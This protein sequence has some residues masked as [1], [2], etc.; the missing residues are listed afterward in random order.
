MGALRHIVLSDL[1]LGALNSVLTNVG[2][3]GVDVDTATAAPVLTSLGACLRTLSAGA[4]PPE[5]VVLGD[6][7]ELAL[8]PLDDAAATFGHFVRAIGLGERDGAVAPHVRFVAGNH[9]HQLWTRARLD[10]EIAIVAATPTDHP[11]PDAAHVT[12]MFPDGDDVPAP[13]ASS[14]RSSGGSASTPT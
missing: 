7:F 2:H 8:T 11:L 10:R 3:G 13:A 5:L 4:E 12:S 14:R 1:H 9:D 6:L